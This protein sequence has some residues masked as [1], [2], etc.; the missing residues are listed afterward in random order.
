MGF[1]KSVMALAEI[2][3]LSV[4]EYTNSDMLIKE[5]GQLSSKNIIAF[6]SE[7]K[8]AAIST[9]FP[10]LAEVIPRQ[11]LE[12]TESNKAKLTLSKN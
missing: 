11:Y 12:S 3:N 2:G 9:S 10:E 6:S 5:N 8:A 4:E 7:V 1:T